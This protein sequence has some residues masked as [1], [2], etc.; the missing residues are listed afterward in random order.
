MLFRIVCCCVRVR[1]GSNGCGVHDDAAQDS[2]MIMSNLENIPTMDSFIG[3][4]ILVFDY[5]PGVLYS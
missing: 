3:S 2:E 4:M 1:C 5:I